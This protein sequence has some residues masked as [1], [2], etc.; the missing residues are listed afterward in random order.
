M[1][2]YRHLPQMNIVEEII[3]V[4]PFARKVVNQELD[5]WRDLIHVNICTSARNIEN[6]PK[7]HALEAEWPAAL[8]RTD[9]KKKEERRKRRKLT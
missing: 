4:K 3:V 1:H 6:K 7:A 9:S 2:A 8:W 5:I